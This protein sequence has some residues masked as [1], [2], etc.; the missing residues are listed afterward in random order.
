MD[1]VGGENT[2]QAVA[3]GST[4]KI[5]Q[6]GPN[7]F[8]FHCSKEEYQ[9][10]WMD[11]FDLRADYGQIKRAI[12]AAA[13]GDSFLT[14]AVDWGAGLRILKQDAWEVVVSFMI[15]QR[16]SIPR[17]KNTVKKLCAPHGNTFPA[18]HVL[19]KHD[20]EF[21]KS[22]GL[23]Y[24]AKYVLDIARAADSGDF[25]IEYLKQL[26]CKEAVAYAKRFNGVGEK[27]ANCIALYGL[28]RLDAFPVDTWIARLI[29][30]RYEGHFGTEKFSPY[31]G[32]VQ[33]YMFFY[34]RSLARNNG[35]TV[36]QTR[37]SLWD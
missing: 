1:G 32:I 29:E 18:P 24:R 15:S 20:E 27:V 28:H 30:G 6:I 31:A 10:T 36:S 23:G 21:F 9:N 33:Q 8:I 16:N 13:N 5:Q 2:W 34:R 35:R 12:L 19:A 14:R 25:D 11:Y 4:L 26:D 17:I 3:L 37:C 22:I 7:R